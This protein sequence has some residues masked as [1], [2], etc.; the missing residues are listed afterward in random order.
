MVQLISHNIIRG[1]K[2][3]HILHGSA[4]RKAIVQGEG[5]LSQ[6]ISVPSK[7][8]QIISLSQSFLKD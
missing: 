4:Q 6:C 7:I 1:K 2:P 3:Q 5:V 8:R